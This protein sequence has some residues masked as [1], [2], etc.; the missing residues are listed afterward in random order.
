MAVKKDFF[1]DIYEKYKY[2]MFSIAMDVLNDKFAAEDAVQEAF[3]KIIKNS[4]K[5]D[6]INSNRTKRLIITITK[7]SAIDIY[8]KQ[9]KRWNTE[10][11]MDKIVDLEKSDIYTIEDNEKFL[12]IEGLPDI[13]KEVLIL[14]YAS[15]FT[16]TEIAELLETSEMNIRKRISRAR[17]LLKQKLDER[18]RANENIY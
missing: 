16:N 15:E 17:K 10:I 14:K 3:L 9:K 6:D 1:Y 2:L 5:I 13:Y 12:E 18:G 11:E 8:R 7:N 4:N